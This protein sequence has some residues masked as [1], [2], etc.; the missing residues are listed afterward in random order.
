MSNKEL[1]VA[2]VEAMRVSDVE[3]LK[4]MITD[5]FTWW[6]TGKPDYLQ[7]AGEHDRDFF[8]GFFGGGADMFPNGADFRVTGMVSEGDKVAAEAHLT[9][10]TAMGTTYDNAYHFLFT[11]DD[12]RIQRM[13]EYMDTHHAKMTF[14]L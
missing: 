13:K 5:D 2:F 6:I 10:Q 12:G 9:A 11:I 1:V 8:F 3:A 14:G 4:S 7:T